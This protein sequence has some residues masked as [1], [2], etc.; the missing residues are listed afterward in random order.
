M[1]LNLI[2]EKAHLASGRYGFFL[3]SLQAIYGLAISNP[4]LGSAGHR[5]KVLKEA[6]DAAAIF[7][8]AEVN[9]IEEDVDAVFREAHQTT[10]ADLDSADR[11]NVPVLAGE[12]LSAIVN[13]LY[14]EVS[15]QVSRDISMLK[16]RIQTAILEISVSARA[17]NSTTRQSQMQY[18][19]MNSGDIRFLFRDRSGRNWSS[20]KFYRQLWRHTLL[21]AYNET[22]IILLADHGLTLAKVFHVDPKADVSGL[23]ISLVSGSL[24][25]IYSEIRDAV[26]H[27]NAN[28]YL[29]YANAETAYVS[30]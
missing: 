9:Y 2:S 6:R 23:M 16:S 17:R 30:S 19:L 26:F 10:I 25:S 5:A 20:E 18:R 3:S 27:P 29:V 28:A 8:N 22:V 24:Y 21:T 14:E 7:L 12:Q 13:Y 11:Q 4:D 15:A 1:L